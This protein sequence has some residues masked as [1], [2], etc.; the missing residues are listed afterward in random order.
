MP[1]PVVFAQ[2][3]E[4]S[5]TI[6][7]THDMHDNLLPSK[8][9]QE[10]EIKTLGGYARLQSAINKIKEVEK[11]VLLVDGGDFSMGTPFQTIFT[12][13]SPSL[14]ILGQMGYDAVTLGNHEFDYRASGLTK[15]LVSAMQSKEQL[16]AIVEANMTFP[17]DEDGKLT[18]SL[19]EL[20]AA[21]DAY[22]VQ[23]Y[24]IVTRNGVK[25]GIFGVMGEESASMAPMSEVVFEDEIKHAKRV[26]KELQ[27]KEQVDLI[28][29]LSHSGTKSDPKKSEDEILAKKVPEIDIII[30]GHTHTKLEEPI[31]VGDT[32]IGSCEE[33]GKYLG[34]IKVSQNGEKD[35]E[36]TNYELLPI[37]NSYPEDPE[38]ASRVAEFKEEVQSQYF[39]EFG[40]GYDEV[41]AST[42]YDFQTTAQIQANHNES[43][44]GNL[45]SDAY[46]YAVKKAEGD[47][48]IPITAAVVPAGTIRGN[49][50]EGD[51]TA[52]DAFSVSSLGIGADKMPGYP[53]IS[54]YLTGKELKTM[55]EVD[56][57]IT[58]LMAEAQLFL[59]GVNFTFHPKR[60]IFNKVEDVTIENEDGTTGKVEDEKLYRVVVG[61]YS[62]QMLSVVGDKSFGLLSIVPK[63]QDG[64]PITDFEKQIIYDETSGT[65][66]EL[67]EW[68]ALV[69]Y[70]QSF[71][72]ENGV[73]KIPTYYSE[74]HER[75][76]VDD[77]NNILVILGNPNHIALVVYGV[78]I[79]L[80]GLVVLVIVKVVKRRRKHR[81]LK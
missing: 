8:S 64:T 16:P 25:V 42:S 68:Y 53:L 3:S 75:K 71:D 35:W 76:V 29:C 5:L 72:Q 38:I 1:S 77:N 30:S 18:E 59:S 28:V 48:Y 39:D 34:I 52:A 19:T 58:P 50:F 45:I 73:A 78:V 4:K 14:R 70:L 67:K 63:T 44:L 21:T 60:L 26:V 62:A 46:R 49:F 55:C 24:I 40:L 7:F 41:I 54:V 15:S 31:I 27:D 20:K 69:Q 57:S 61:L 13:S 32:L 47:N 79:L 65:K 36:L 10:G 74:T 23:D 51:I 81:N 2:E 6:L 66:R 80:M 9:K 33:Y 22:G 37:D 17:I 43:T 12:G 11:E 56:A